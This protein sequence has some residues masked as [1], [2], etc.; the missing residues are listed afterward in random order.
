ME[1]RAERQEW[2]MGP[3]V[4]VWIAPCAA[5]NTC[6]PD[7]VREFP[8]TSAIQD[9]HDSITTNNMKGH[10]TPCNGRGERFGF[11]QFFAE[12]SLQ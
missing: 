2:S 7:C 4:A 10:I 11:L 9:L 5:M 8:W 1:L 3:S 12:Q 6:R